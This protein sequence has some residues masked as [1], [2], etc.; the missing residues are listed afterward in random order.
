MASFKVDFSQLKQDRDK[1][2]ERGEGGYPQLPLAH[3][4]HSK[5]DY[6]RYGKLQ[7]YKSSWHGLSRTVQSMSNN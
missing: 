1:E 6:K 4:W 7:W 5:T 3:D 2:R